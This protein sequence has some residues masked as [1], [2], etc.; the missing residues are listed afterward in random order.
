[1]KK[2]QPSSKEQKAVD[3]AGGTFISG[4]V[5]PGA[6]FVGRDKIIQGDEVAGDKISVNLTMP[7]PRNSG[8]I[9]LIGK[10]VQVY[11]QPSVLQA[12]LTSS[13]VR[14]RS[15][16]LPFVALETLIIY[17]YLNFGV[18]FDVPQWLPIAVSI[19]TALCIWGYVHWRTTQIS[20]RMAS[21]I[22]NLA[23]VGLLA[24]QYWTIRYP[25]PFRPEVFGVAL[26]QLGEGPD[27]TPTNASRLV[28][29]QIR[30]LL[31]A[32][33]PSEQVTIRQVPAISTIETAQAY[34]NTI[35]A[36]LV[37][38]GQVISSEPGLATI[39]FSV[40][41]V[42][43]DINN[44]DFPNVFPITIRSDN[45]A[46]EELNLSLEM[47]ELKRAI[48]NQVDVISSLIKG[49]FYYLNQDFPKAVIHLRKSADSIENNRAFHVAP[50]SEFAIYYYLASAYLRLNLLPEGQYWLEKAEALA[51]DEP[52]VPLSLAFSYSAQRSRKKFVDNLEKTLK[53]LDR[54]LRVKP[55]DV[56]ARY[57]RA[58]AYA[59][60]NNSRRAIVDY[61]TI[62]K[63]DPDYYLAYVGLGRV[64]RAA[65]R[66]E[67]SIAV[68]QEGIQVAERT[69]RNGAGAWLELARAYQESNRP[70]LAE[71]G[72]KTALRY[73]PNVYWMH[74]HFGNFLED[75]G[76]L[77]EAALEF[78]KVIDTSDD[79]A[80]GYGQAA[81]FHRRI[82]DFQTAIEY[83]EKS[84]I[85]NPDS[86]IIQTYVAET[87]YDIGEIESAW[88]AF[89]EAVK[90]D[91]ILYYPFGSYASRLIQ[92]GQL[93]KALDLAEQ[94]ELQLGQQPTESQDRQNWLTLAWIY[95]NL[96]QC[97]SALQTLTQ[98]EA[99]DFPDL[100]SDSEQFLAR[101]NQILTLCPAY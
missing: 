75:N 44:P 40:I 37:I 59:L 26:A 90:L 52:S 47:D 46:V 16:I 22:G 61:Q 58:L 88:A 5:A 54:H 13:F 53:L 89:D 12:F 17:L 99:R 98:A 56:H 92:N 34:G 32:Q 65:G 35:K 68:L 41:S 81:G 42:P 73:A 85:E 93:G 19:L 78:E 4:D 100:D 74:Y 33:L 95:G 64:F 27:Y 57:A 63:T 1:M 84:L 72:F 23:L 49:M 21:L 38:W 24:W 10:F 55:D 8:P 48:L 70:S 71:E 9:T 18:R 83:Y 15:F 87:L 39:R 94:Y 80:W 97:K 43:E 79:K 91:G 3:T 14:F 76:R 50:E 29:G 62:I 30:E 20:G 69:N 45:F 77:D 101:K 96:G 86:A 2:S 25:I 66:F 7:E 67:E 51:P 36:D 60:D 6:D 82:G 11:D 28:T 31:M